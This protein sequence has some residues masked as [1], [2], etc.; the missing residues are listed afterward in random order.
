MTTTVRHRL[1]AWAP[2]LCALLALGLFIALA[3]IKYPLV[4]DAQDVVIYGEIAD[5]AIAA[6]KDAS[7]AVNSEYPPLATA[8]FWLIRQLIPGVPFAMP[9]LAAMCASAVCAW[10]YLRC[11]DLR[12]AAVFAWVLPV[13]VVLL[14]HDMIFSRFDYFV[15]VPLLL[16][17][18][19]YRYNAF[20]EAAGWL[21]AAVFLK[22]V[23]VIA[24][25]L[26]ALALPRRAYVPA[27]IGCMVAF[28][29]A[30]AIS[31]GALGLQGSLDNVW[32]V[33]SYHGDRVIQLETV[34]S[35]IAMLAAFAAGHNPV[36]G[37]DHMSVVNFDVPMIVG[38]MS[39][40]LILGS[41]AAIAYRSYRTRTLAQ[42][43]PL[44]LL[45]LSA[46]LV[47]SP[48][49]SPQ[50]FVWIVPLL[51]FYVA[52]RFLE[53]TLSWPVVCIAAC[54]VILS[55]QTQWIFPYHYMELVDRHLWPVIVLNIRNLLLC[56]LTAALAADTGLLPAMR[57]HALPAQQLL[58]TLATDT[59]F[60][61]MAVTAFVVCRP[62][63]VTSV[64]HATVN[65]GRQTQIASQMPVSFDAP[66]QALMTVRTSLA[67]RKFSQ[68]RFFR[69][70]V[71]DCLES[72]SV[73]GEMLPQDSGYCDGVGP[74][75]TF[76]LGAYL[77]TGANAVVLTVRNGYAGPVGVDI[78]PAMTA[79]LF[80]LI[81]LLAGM[82]VWYTVAATR[83]VLHLVSTPAAAQVLEML[84]NPFVPWIRSHS[85]PETSS[86]VL[87]KT[88]AEISI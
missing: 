10:A 2:D 64:S 67:V 83:T 59:F 84:Y 60:V 8:L 85:A 52:H 47:F 25:P 74:G 72:V 28:G 40:L 86:I 6:M 76:D 69:I 62:L 63:L 50:Y 33:L 14:G 56:I 49:L 19:M 79:R 32:Y 71:D 80:L 46:A 66:E 87:P 23:P 58:R 5:R 77:K 68:N 82:S 27:L 65:L 51:L 20:P 48:V 73:N 16:S 36:I 11:Y 24:V 37:Y 41:V 57:P 70:R 53:R 3:V 42:Y 45:A 55:L 22:I 43:G 35:G 54:T 13:S 26:L 88:V 9:W 4:R 34:W 15:A 39:S 78:T 61:A 18:R 12:D 7:V 1:R 44:M 75:R 30:S 38:K 31:V 21:C 17:W 29:A 81:L